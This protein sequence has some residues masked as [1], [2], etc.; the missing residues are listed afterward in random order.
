MSEDTTDAASASTTGGI[1]AESETASSS[2]TQPEQKPIPQNEASEA[3]P[4]LANLNDLD[5][6]QRVEAFTSVL[7][8]LH[9]RLDDVTG[10]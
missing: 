2:A 3:F 9:K 10:R 1:N 5:D 7:S 8:Q 4:E 6:S